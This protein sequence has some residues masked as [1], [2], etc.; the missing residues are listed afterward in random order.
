MNYDLTTI[1]AYGITFGILIMTI[2]YTLIRFIASKEIIYISYCFMQVFSLGYILFYS[3]L[4]YTNLI[5]QDIFLV[6]ASFSAIVFALSFYEG[7]FFPPLTN[8]KELIVNTILLNIVI[9]TSFYHY[10]LFE[11]LPYTIIYAILFLSVIFNIKDGFKPTIVY[12][13]GWS[14]LCFLLFI[15]EFKQIYVDQQY[16]DI[17]LLAFAIEAILFTI[18]VSYKYGS[19]KQQ[20]KS[21]E[22]MLLQQSK[23]A[24]SGEMIANITHQ[25]RQPLNNISYILINIKKRFEK[26]KL[27]ESYFTNKVTQI[28]EQLQFLS[29]TI[30][31]FKEF[32]TPSKQKENFLIKEAIDSSITVLSAELKKR[33]IILNTKY[34]VNEDINIKGIKNELSQ[35]ILAILTNASDALKDIESPFINIQIDASDAEI[36]ISISNNGKHIDKRDINKI[37]EPYFSTKKDGTGIGLYLSKLIINRSFDGELKVEN[38]KDGVQFSLMFDKTV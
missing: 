24:Q 30:D 11:Y 2:I 21:Y 35:V 19:L 25:F 38:I 37:F 31:H 34:N 27:E 14:V 28:D 17:V 22:D 36:I 1:L 26:K 18:S 20:T 13:I 12:V 32:Y 16:L 23:M 4:F 10:V 7:K 15:F 33:N 5:V 29:T 9:L 6:F 8:V 3:Q